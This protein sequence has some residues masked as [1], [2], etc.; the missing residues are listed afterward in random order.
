MVTG[1]AVVAVPASH[2]ADIMW[3]GGQDGSQSLAEYTDVRFRKWYHMD[4]HLFS[5]LL[6]CILVWLDAVWSVIIAGIIC[7]T[8]CLKWLMSIFVSNL[9]SAWKWIQNQCAEYD[10]F[11]PNKVSELATRI[12]ILYLRADSWLVEASKRQAHSFVSILLIVGLVVVVVSS[13][14][15]IALNVHREGRTMVVYMVDAVNRTEALQ[16]YLPSG[17]DINSL[18]ESVGN[19]TY[20]YARQIIID[21]GTET[22]GDSFNITE[23]E[24][25][26]ERLWN[27]RTN[28]THE[29]PVE[30]AVR[31]ALS[32]NL[33]AAYDHLQAGLQEDDDHTLLTGIAKFDLG[34]LTTYLHRGGQVLTQNLQLG[35]AV[36]WYLLMLVITQSVAVGQFAVEVT[37][38]L[39][40]L[41][42]LL[43]KPTYTPMEKF[44][45][46]LPP[47]MQDRAIEHV[48]R[49]INAVFV[50]TCKM[51]FFHGVLPRQ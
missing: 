28:I 42:Y 4:W 40:A 47:D 11:L 29:L 34:S 18:K 19:K 9:K 33:T 49:T 17:D 15:I 30:T 6:S 22:F 13:T 45:E 12:W 46:W 36:I 51:S 20:T 2:D 14:T 39:L 5:L 50:V 10:I 23:I 21:R 38:Y 44:K 26:I 48:Y 7:L 35:C 25:G 1:G 16:E 3:A 31:L 37:T 41:F 27:N 8:P 24:A 43:S 32:G